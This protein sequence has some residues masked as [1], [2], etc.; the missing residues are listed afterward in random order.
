MAAGGS[1]ENARARDVWALA[2]SL[3]AAFFLRGALSPHAGG[4]APSERAEAAVGPPRRARKVERR[5]RSA[6][7]R[8]KYA[9][10]PV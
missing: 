3:Y 8:R 5:E 6:W 9:A 1:A 4:A 10:E 7:W 2:L